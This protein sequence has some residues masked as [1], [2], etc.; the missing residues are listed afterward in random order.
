MTAWEKAQLVR[1]HPERSVFYISGPLKPLDGSFIMPLLPT[2]TLLAT[3]NMQK[4]PQELRLT[5][6]TS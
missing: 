6:T 2:K 1:T 4:F 5:R 3:Y